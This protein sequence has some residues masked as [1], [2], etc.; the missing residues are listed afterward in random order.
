MGR[1]GRRRCAGA[2]GIREEGDEYHK[3][4]Q[5]EK[6]DSENEERAFGLA[7]EGAHGTKGTI[8][9][10]ERS[11]EAYELP[12]RVAS[13]D[14]DMEIMH[15]NRAKMVAVALDIL[16]H[17]REAPLRALD[18]GA[19]TGFF[20]Q[21]FL[22]AF[23]R[24]RVVAVDGARAMVDLATVRLGALAE[25][26]RFVVGDFRKL[27]TLD[28][29]AEPFDVV[30]SSF[31]L[32]HMNAADKT[33]LI[34]RALARTRPGGWF[35]DADILAAETPEIERLVQQRRVEGIVRRAAGRDAR[36]ADAAATRAFID[37]VEAA[38]G[39]QPQTLAAD[40]EILRAAGVRG[41]SLFWLELREAVIGGYR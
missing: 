9:M 34:A 17:D 7:D 25:R 16:P 24:S 23:P 26:V 30:Y 10:S 19:G 3:N 40:L 8:A 12:A 2:R 35:V 5:G 6:V 21:R 37:G 32:H 15:P 39:D 31:A 13:Y 14:A 4:D 38:D 33:T 18:L 22:E 29:G 28:L 41:A 1:E 36:F 27:D 11:I 20:T